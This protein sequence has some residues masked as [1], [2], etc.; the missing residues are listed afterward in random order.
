MQTIN[1]MSRKEIEEIVKHRC[2]VLRDNI[3]EEIQKFHN[4]LNDLESIIKIYNGKVSFK[5]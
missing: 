1:I 4:R 5:K 2:E 3:F